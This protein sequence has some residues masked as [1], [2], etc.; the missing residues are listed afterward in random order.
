MIF[1]RVMLIARMKRKRRTTQALKTT[2]CID[3][4]KESRFGVQYCR[5][6]ALP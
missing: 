6:D 3:K 2:P 5:I 1:R 4:G